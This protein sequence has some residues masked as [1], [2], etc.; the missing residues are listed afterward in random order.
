[1]IA[2]SFDTKIRNGQID[3]PTQYRDKFLSDVKVIL[4]PSEEATQNQTYEALMQE[5][6]KDK[7]FLSRTIACAEDFAFVD[8]EVSGEW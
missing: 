5:A 1:M 8:G 6:G 4:L 2:I 3:I 7:G